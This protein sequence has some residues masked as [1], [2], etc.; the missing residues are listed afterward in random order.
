[1]QNQQSIDAFHAINRHRVNSQVAQIYTFIKTVGL[2][3][4][5]RISEHFHLD[6]NIVESR[7]SQLEREGAIT[8]TTTLDQATGNH[9][10]TWKANP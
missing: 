1:M 10:R 7:T 9:S 2:A 3:N 4:D 8:R 6:R 5:R